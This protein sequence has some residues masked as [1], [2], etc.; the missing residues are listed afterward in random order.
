MKRSFFA[1]TIV[2][3]AAVALVQAQTPRPSPSAPA[4]D[5]RPR[6][7]LPTATPAPANISKPRVNVPVEQQQSEIAAPHG[8]QL[9]NKTQVVPNIA[10]PAAIVR[11][12]ET[13]PAAALVMS[14]PLIRTRISEAERLLRS[15]PQPTSLTTPSTDFVTLAALDHSSGRIHLLTLSKDTFLTKGAELLM[16]SSLGVPLTVRI[17]RANG[18]NT[19][20]AI[21]D[22]QGRSLVPLVVQFPI[23]KGGVFREMAYYTSAHPALLSPDL[24]RAGRAYVH[25]MMMLAV[26]RLRE[27]GTFISP[28]IV[29]VAERLCL[30]ER[31][32]HDRFRLE[33]RLAL[34]D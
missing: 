11:R 14:P 6:P 24:S 33:N 31:V 7:A 19:A 1:L 18:V 26:Q 12:A 25:R 28:Q 3:S 32:D 4:P 10:G 34:F 30:V 29:D 15:R 5:A 27:K 21:F 17:L 22:A 9:G 20:V 13:T 16:T 8:T 23:E 2:F